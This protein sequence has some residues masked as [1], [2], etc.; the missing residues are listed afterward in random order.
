MLVLGGCSTDS[1]D[2]ED[3][4]GDAAS[5]SDPTAI[6]SPDVVEERLAAGATAIDVRTPEEVAA[7]ALPGAITI[8]VQSADFDARVAELDPEA[9]YVVYCRSGNRSAAAIERMVD[10]GFTDLV[11][12]GGYDDLVAAGVGS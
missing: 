8:D 6:V 11:N 3:S 2:S 12:G 10:L 1:T 7:G 4:A 5:A 9:S